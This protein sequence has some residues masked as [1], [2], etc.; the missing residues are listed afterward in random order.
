MKASAFVFALVLALFGCISVL[1]YMSGGREARLEIIE[2]RI[3][4]LEMDI[5]VLRTG[6]LELIKYA[7]LHDAQ[8]QSPVKL[9]AKLD[10]LQRREARCCDAV[11]PGEPCIL[12]VVD[13]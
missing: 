1:A 4:V 8:C 5:H 12:C 10:R 6:M 2:L 13:Q 9:M 3:E 11:P 7:K